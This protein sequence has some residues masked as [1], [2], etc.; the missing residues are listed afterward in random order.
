MP[1]MMPSTIKPHPHPMQPLAALSSDPAIAAPFHKHQNQPRRH[2]PRHRPPM[3]SADA[4]GSDY[5]DASTA[6]LSLS[7]VCARI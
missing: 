2:H 6:S 3:R 1:S 7:G 4:R 5:L